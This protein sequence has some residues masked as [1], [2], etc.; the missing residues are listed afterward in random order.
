MSKHSFSR[1]TSIGV[2][3]MLLLPAIPELDAQDVGIGTF[4]D[5]VGQAIESAPGPVIQ[6]P[7]SY[8][9]EGGKLIEPIAAPTQNL[10]P[11]FE[12]DYRF[13]QQK[14]GDRFG[15]DINEAHASFMLISGL[16]KFLVEYFHVWTD[17]SNDETLRKTSQV[18]G[19]KASITETIFQNKPQKSQ[20]AKSVVFSLPFFL[21][22][23]DL[24]A[25]SATARRISN[26]DSYT[27]NPFFIL[28]VSW[29]LDE[30]RY[31]NLKL[32]L[33]PGYRLTFSDKN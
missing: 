29:P 17:A 32:S 26:I 22:S 13:N 20:V 12:Y 25:L 1:V 9:L 15:T 30:D 14:T 33:S 6:P 19:I 16:T 24:D 11:G 8:S 28:S 21:R 2:V 5:L 7:P 3:F 18:N 4:N 10:Q 23:E 27:L 31:R